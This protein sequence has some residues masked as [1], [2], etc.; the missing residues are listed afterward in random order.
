M[1]IA[2]D[3]ENYGASDLRIQVSTDAA[4]GGT[5][6]HLAA[7][8]PESCNHISLIPEEAGVRFKIGAA[9]TADTSLLPLGGLTFNGNASTLEDIHL[10]AAS[11]TYVHV[12]MGSVSCRTVLGA[13]FSTGDIQIG[14]VEIKDQDGT[15]RADVMADGASSAKNALVTHDQ[16]AVASLEAMDN[17][18]SGLTFANATFVKIDQT[19][20]A[21]VTALTT[22]ATGTQR[23]YLMGLFGTMEAAGALT[24]E[25]E[26]GTDLSGPMPIGANGGIVVGGAGYPV[27]KTSVNA[28]DLAINTTQKFYGHAV[29]IVQ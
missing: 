16:R 8:L 24:I 10:Y 23:V 4:L 26:D 14:A 3:F 6:G 28:K 29:C 25:D 5:S 19:A 20:A 15:T 12:V 2:A 13:S 22:G 11:A 21:G 27:L 17:G 1:T 7:A 18:I 9:A